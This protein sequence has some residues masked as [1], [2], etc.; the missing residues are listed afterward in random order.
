M[1][2]NAQ[3]LDLG[4]FFTRRVKNGNQKSARVGNLLDTLLS[5]VDSLD[6][7]SFKSHGER[8]G[9]W[10]FEAE[11]YRPAYLHGC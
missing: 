6:V 7:S 2:W 10:P 5:G 8:R 4:Q 11:E 1:C 3:L 9:S